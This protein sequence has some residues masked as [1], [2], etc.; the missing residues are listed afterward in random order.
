MSARTLYFF[1]VSLVSIRAI[2]TTILL[3]DWVDRALTNAACTFLLMWHFITLPSSSNARTEMV[4]SQA[5]N[6]FLQERSKNFL[7][8]D[9]IIRGGRSDVRSVTNSIYDLNTTCASAC[10]Q[11]GHK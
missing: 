1:D 2:L 5:T 3:P 10:P 8:V 7:A 6:R 11:I 9:Q 4:G